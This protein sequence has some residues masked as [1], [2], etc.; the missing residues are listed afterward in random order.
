MSTRLRLTLL[1]ALAVILVS[2]SLSAVFDDG[3]WVTPSLGALATVSLACSLA[4]GWRLPRPVVPVVGLV[5]LV[6]FLTTAFVPEPAV[7]RI[8]PGP[9]AW[10]ALA[11]L[12]RD[13][14][15]DLDLYQAPV[16]PTPAL[17]AL[18]AGGIGLI[19][20]VV[21][22]A[23]V[24]YRRASVGGLALLGLF[25]VPATLS[26][27][28]VGPWLFLLAASG[29]LVLLVAESRDRIARWGRPMGYR[30]AEAPS[31]RRYVQ[32]SSDPVST[33]GRRVGLASLGIAIVVPLAL[34]GLD[35]P[36]IT[37]PGPG[38]GSGAGHRTVAVIN[39]IIDL[40]SNLVRGTDTEVIRYRSTDATPDYLRMVTLDDFTGQ[41]WAPTALSNIPSTQRVDNG[42]PAVPGR[43]AAVPA[44]R[45]QTTI[46]VRDLAQRWLPLP[47]GA[48]YVD[49]NGTWL[50]DLASRNVFS[51]DATTQ[52]TT[53]SVTSL[54]GKPTVE[55]LAAATTSGPG[56]GTDLELP[57]MPAV[58][59]DTAKT[60]TAK[61]G[62]PY[63]KALRLQDWL[64]SSAFTYSTDAP[65]ASGTTAI[66]AFLRDRRGFCVHYASAMAVMARS[67]GIPAR[68]DVGFTPG[69]HQSDGTWSV[70][71]R[72]AHSWPELWFDGVGWLRFEPTPS[73][74]AQTVPPYA[75]G[76]GVPGGNAAEQQ[77]L[78][79]AGAGAGELDPRL[80]RADRQLD[81]RDP[82]ANRSPTSSGFGGGVGTVDPPGRPLWPFAALGTGVLAV[83]AV[84]GVVRL[85]RRRLRR[86]RA[87]SAAEAGWDQ[88]RDDMRDLGFAWSTSE[89]PRQLAERLCEEAPLLPG[90]EAATSLRTLVAV[91][92]RA[93]YAPRDG[94]GSAADVP[95]LSGTVRRGMAARSARWRRV[96][97]LVVPTS[98]LDLVHGAG[99]R[100]ADMLDGIDRM[101]TRRPKGRGGESAARPG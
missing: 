14:Q 97:A 58:V 21:D 16:A 88:L 93:R 42:M 70:T 38:R 80:T 91:V 98:T 55:Q 56:S 11:D 43:S 40:R 27:S 19:L 6:T 83:L 33:V 89:T 23:A 68:V 12:A 28:G 29:W 61:G 65:N 72:D 32:G 74:R 7:W 22:A 60:V 47:Y 36:L 100:V 76:T 66:E 37:G 62:T 24:T 92:E 18:T 54:R 3:S 96:R 99:A 45:V 77:A 75:Q 1:S 10:A 48:G 2:A 59:A 9:A 52:R 31:E 39:P 20:I 69:R 79:G 84:P 63:D 73:V 101:T 34:P 71:L 95:A 8:W 13:A 26:P 51:T 94:T 35:H 87:T 90:S 85:G 78:T 5:A 41:S 44:D 25:A 64:R 81:G 46:A 82:D 15:R 50:Y 30:A 86:A 17:V 53:Y 4:R 49:I 57:A 67:L